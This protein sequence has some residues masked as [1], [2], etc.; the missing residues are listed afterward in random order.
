M[1]PRQAK[2]KR[3]YHQE[4][5]SERNVEGANLNGKAMTTNSEKKIIKTTPPKKQVIKSLIR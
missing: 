1:L 4:T 2:I 5:S 3:V